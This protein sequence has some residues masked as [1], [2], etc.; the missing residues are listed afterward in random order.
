MISKVANDL[1]M[2]YNITVERFVELN[3]CKL[4]KF[5]QENFHG[6]LNNT[7]SICK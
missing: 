2:Y 5:L 4:T 1:G 6:A 3:F 7:A